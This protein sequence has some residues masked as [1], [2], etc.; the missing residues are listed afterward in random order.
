MKQ[1]WDGILEWTFSL[2]KWLWGAIR[3]RASIIYANTSQFAQRVRSSSSTRW[4]LTAIVLPIFLILTGLI[5][6]G[7]Y[8]NLQQSLTLVG[9]SLQIVGIGVTIKGLRDLREQFGIE[10]PLKSLIRSIVILE[11]PW[12]ESATFS[13]PKKITARSAQARQ[14]VRASVDPLA[15]NEQ[16]IKNDKV[17]KRFEKQDEGLKELRERVTGLEEQRAQYFKAHQSLKKDFKELGAELNALTES[18]HLDTIG[19]YCLMAGTVMVLFSVFV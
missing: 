8:G 7:V 15:S 5:H 2:A 17:R 10:G 4:L 3:K 13:T 16:E 14:G 12:S 1:V 18:Y 6:W 9:T 11:G 19:L